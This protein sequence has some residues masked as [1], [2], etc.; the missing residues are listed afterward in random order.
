MGSEYEVD[1]YVGVVWMKLKS[2]AWNSL[3]FSYD[4]IRAHVW[5]CEIF[6]IHRDGCMCEGQIF[7]LTTHIV[8]CHNLCI[9]QMG[10]IWVYSTWRHSEPD[11]VVWV[12]P[13]L[14]LVCCDVPDPNAA[15][16]F[17]EEVLMVGNQTVHNFWMNKTFQLVE[18]KLLV[19][20]GSVAWGR[21]DVMGPQSIQYW[22]GG[23]MQPYISHIS[24]TWT[25]CG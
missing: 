2:V 17:Y 20:A 14:V 4:V 13:I 11:C 18:W 8:W 24:P 5:S 23:A 10:R 16:Q 3:E 22:Y 1:M 19:W 15:C 7:C 6:P 12:T 9:I 21:E 25:W